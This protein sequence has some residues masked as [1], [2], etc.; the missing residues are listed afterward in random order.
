VKQRRS[1]THEAASVGAARGFVNEVLHGVPAEVR[2]VIV[3]M[4]SELASNCVRHTDSDFDLTIS[5]IGDEICVEAS[6]CGG[7]E[8]RMRTPAPT[9]PSGRGLQIVDMFAT[10]WGHESRPGEGKT[11]WF[12]VS[13]NV[14]TAA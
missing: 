2:D 5:Q 11:V 10:S 6:D 9:D 7:G 4:V 1:F 13:L 8:P 14:A 12:R 3:L